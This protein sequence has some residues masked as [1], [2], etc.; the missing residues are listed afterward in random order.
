MSAPSLEIRG[1]ASPEEI[2]AIV[3]VLQAVAASGTAAAP[4]RP[5]SEWSVPRRR[6]RLEHHHTGPG[7]WKA[8]ALPR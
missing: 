4:A 2:A 6:L 5:P 1:D 7:A 8:S 3:T